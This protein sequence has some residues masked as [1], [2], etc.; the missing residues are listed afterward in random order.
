MAGA[1]MGVWA[2]WKRA[3][4][5]G[6]HGV[7]LV[8]LLVVMSLVSLY[9]IWCS[10]FEGCLMAYRSYDEQYALLAYTL[11]TALACMWSDDLGDGLGDEY[12]SELSKPKGRSDRIAL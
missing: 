4:G 1:E 7:G 12:Y 11:C 3:K 2:E 9:G 6:W 10:T 5:D 8:G